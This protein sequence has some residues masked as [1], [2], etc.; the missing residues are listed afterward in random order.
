MLH[1]QRC[2]VWVNHGTRRWEFRQ[3]VKQSLFPQI[4]KLNKVKAFPK[5]VKPSLD[6]VTQQQI[7]WEAHMGSGPPPVFHGYGRQIRACLTARYG[8]RATWRDE[9]AAHLALF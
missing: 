3:Q 9:S 8:R 6:E 2:N 7:S 1:R 5:P 4:N